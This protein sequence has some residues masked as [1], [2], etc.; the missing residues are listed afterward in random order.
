V[1]R[2]T[3]NNLMNSSLSSETQLRSRHTSDTLSTA[4]PHFTLPELAV[5][6]AKSRPIARLSY[7]PVALSG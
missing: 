3:S 1:Q 4:T 2:R 5:L 6:P 7:Q